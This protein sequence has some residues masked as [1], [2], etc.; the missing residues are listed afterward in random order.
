[1][2]LSV[3]YRDYYQILGVPRDAKPDAVKKAY[4]KLAAKFHPDVNKDKGAEDK[5]KE[6]NEAYEVLSDPEKRKLY[7]E[8]GSNWQAGQ[9]FRP[10]PG[11]EQQFRPGSGERVRARGPHGAGP[12]GAAEFYV[13]DFSDFF[14]ALFGG[15]GFGAGGFR[16]A[17][18]FGRGFEGAGG[19]GPGAE[20]FRQAR[21]GGSMK[22]DTHEAEL[23]ISIVEAINGARKRISLSSMQPGEAASEPKVK[24]YDV[25][26]PAGST[27]GTVIR[28]AGQGGAGVGGGASGDLLLRIRVMP[29]ETYSLK[30]NDLYVRTRVAPWE[31]VLGSQIDVPL[32]SG[33]VRMKIPPGAQTGM[34]LR[35]KGKGA[36]GKTGDRGDAYVDI[37]IAVP[38]SPSKEE[39]ELFEKLAEVSKFDPRKMA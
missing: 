25:T 31:A 27:D 13:G 18:G 37:E 16:Q 29:D 6:I 30:G 39:Q 20:F 5:F 11:W 9:E 4:R 8:L 10:P 3:S 19:E 34:K 28:L 33:S 7:D 32:P 15:G 14:E 2:H 21:G 1:M 26:V 17:R 36:K 23:A 24:T 35:L 22:G 12:Q 38:R